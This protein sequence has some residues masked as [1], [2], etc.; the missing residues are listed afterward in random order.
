MLETA[1]G[2]IKLMLPP[3]YAYMVINARNGCPQ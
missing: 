2:E 1:V 3:D